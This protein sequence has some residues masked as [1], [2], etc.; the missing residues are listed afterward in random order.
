MGERLW[1]RADEFTDYALCAGDPDFV[2]APEA[3]GRGR[4]AFVEATC[5]RCPVRPECIE[6]NVQPVTMS[7]TIELKKKLNLPSS[8]VWVAGVWLPDDGTAASK[9]L[10]EERREALVDSVATEYAS[11]PDFL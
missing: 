11:R 4:T 7:D 2:I 3:L 8:G 10:L 9:R 6:M 1:D 5:R